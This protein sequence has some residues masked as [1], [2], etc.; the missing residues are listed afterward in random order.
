MA[1]LLRNDST[2]VDSLVLDRQQGSKSHATGECRQ[3]T[4]SQL[5]LPLCKDPFAL[6]E[7][8]VELVHL[9]LL[10]YVGKYDAYESSSSST[11]R[12]ILTHTGTQHCSSVMTCTT[13]SWPGWNMLV[14][15]TEAARVRHFYGDRSR[16]HSRWTSAAHSLRF[17]SN[18]N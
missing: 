6:A 7:D 17:G 14:A 15:L 4:F 13:I 1:D 11:P 3:F 10:G 8:G 12:T 2:F 5:P 16:Y 18:G 9:L